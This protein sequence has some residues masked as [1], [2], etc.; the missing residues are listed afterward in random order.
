[1]PLS[2]GGIV[3]GMPIKSAVYAGAEYIFFWGAA[4]L[5]FSEIFYYFLGTLDRLM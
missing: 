3:F 1:M 4:M 5:A 2:V